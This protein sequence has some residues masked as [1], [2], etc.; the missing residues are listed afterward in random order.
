MNH[1]VFIYSFIYFSDG[2]VGA[3]V[4]ASM[5]RVPSLSKDEKQHFISSVENSSGCDGSILLLSISNR[6]DI[7][8]CDQ[9]YIGDIDM[10]SI[11]YI[12]ALFGLVTFTLSPQSESDCRRG[13]CHFYISRP[14]VKLWRFQSP[15]S[16]VVVFLAVAASDPTYMAVHC[17]R[18]CFRWLEAA[19]GTVCRPTSPQLELT[20]FF[21]TASKLLFS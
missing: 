13:N 3:S 4:A 2:L 1:K 21:R 18:S 11:S 15:P 17:W 19:S 9:I 20:S 7:D 16:P 14:T 6:Y 8:I 5:C 12:A 10:S